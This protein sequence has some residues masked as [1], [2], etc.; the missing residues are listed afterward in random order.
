MTDHT[1]LTPTP[2]MGWN[3]FNAYGCAASEKTLLPNLEAMAARL[4]PSGY[5]Y[6]VVDNG[7]FAEYDL[8]PGQDYPVERHAAEVRIDPYG[9]YLPSRCSFPRGLQ[10]LIERTH[11]LGLRFGIH[12]MRGISRKAVRLDLPILGTPYRARD[13]AD[14]GSL[15][16]WCPYN[17]G[18]DMSKPGAQAFYDS[19]VALLASWGVDF[20]KADDIT[21]YPDEIAGI[22]EAIARCGRPI[23]FSLSPGGD[24]DRRHLAAYRR[25]DML[26]TTRDIW[27]N[28]VSLDRAF[29]AW[30]DWAGLGGDR[31]WLDLD[32]IPFGHL[33][34]CRPRATAPATLGEGQNA[35]LAG[36]GY[37]RMSLLTDE[38]QYTFITMRALAA[39]PLFMGGD[40]PTSDEFSLAL[41]ANPAMIACDQN[42]VVGTRVSCR[43]GIEAWRTPDRANPRAGWFGIFNRRQQRQTVALPV[44]DLGLAG[45]PWA[46]HDIW[47]DRDL[48]QFRAGEPLRHDIGPDG[49]LFCRYRP[50]VEA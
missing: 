36:K 25:A 49:V 31:F 37:E 11:R 24:A 9:R 40:L 32:M 45:G 1:G 17:Y 22:A 39:S 6:F 19:V 27:D 21:G 29:A 28:R 18:V 10:P 44:A 50:V 33:L 20:I 35:E 12:L 15:C 42:G 13:I 41:I 38:Q 7:W 48:G 4:K 5:Q 14:T 2:P 43:E 8:A 26:R 23:V 16:R 30:H 46:F 34:L 47:G 3:S